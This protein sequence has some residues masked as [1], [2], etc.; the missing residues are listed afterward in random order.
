[1]LTSSPLI[2]VFGAVA[3][4]PYWLIAGPVGAAAIRR[5]YRRQAMDFGVEGPVLPYA[6]VGSAIFV[7][8]MLTGSVGGALDADLVAVTGP[9]L[10]ISAGLLAFA[11]LDRSA[12]EAVVVVA[13]AVFTLLLV[14]SGMDLER[15]P[16]FVA[17]VY[18]AVWLAAG[19]FY[20]RLQR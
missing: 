6:L 4:A 20:R 12:G 17:L 15:V 3:L 7:G 11:W 5:Y 14:A 1:M 2:A 8:S 9:P 13:L 18:G 16:I 19:L 10:V